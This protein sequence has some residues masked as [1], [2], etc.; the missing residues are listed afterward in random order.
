MIKDLFRIDD[1]VAIITGSGRGIGAASAVALAQYGAHVVIASRTSS[2]LD[3]VAH[4]VE[5]LDRRAV[6]VPCD[7]SDLGAIAGLAEVARREFGR[8][9][10]VVNNVG[11]AVP[12]PFLMTTPE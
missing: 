9:D 7:L 3:Q 12:L 2:D 1:K 6:A 5:E 4:A 11:G 10:I 8:V